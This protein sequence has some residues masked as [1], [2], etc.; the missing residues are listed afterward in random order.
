M[1]Y[2]GC[3]MG[4][5]LSLARPCVDGPYLSP[6]KHVWFWFC[7]VSAPLV[8]AGEDEGKYGEREA[9]GGMGAGGARRSGAPRRWLRSSRSLCHAATRPLLALQWRDGRRARRDRACRLRRLLLIL[10]FPLLCSTGGGCL[11]CGHE[12]RRGQGEGER[13]RGVRRNAAP[14]E[15]VFVEM[16]MRSPSNL[17][18]SINSRHICGKSRTSPT[19]S[20]FICPFCLNPLKSIEK[21]YEYGA[22]C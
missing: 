3:K 9:R 6:S 2:I 1:E 21:Y 17:Q 14:G 12:V 4:P 7:H 5:A 13:R 19:V 16:Q 22:S 20:F 18:L 8:A 11:I 15:I 10:V